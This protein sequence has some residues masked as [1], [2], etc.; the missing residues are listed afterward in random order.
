M[1]FLKQ[2]HLAHLGFAFLTVLFTVRRLVLLRHCAIFY[3]N[4]VESII[5]LVQSLPLDKEPALQLLRKHPQPQI[6]IYNPLLLK[7]ECS[8][9]TP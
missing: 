1:L 2:I 5:Q 9:E 8:N 4:V 6:C 3:Q 7:T